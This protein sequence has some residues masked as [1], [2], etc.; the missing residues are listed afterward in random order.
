MAPRARWCTRASAANGASMASAA[1]ADLP[2]AA[3]RA[4]AVSARRGRG[5]VEHKTHP[6]GRLEGRRL[7]RV[8]ID[9]SPQTPRVYVDDVRIR[10]VRVVPYMLK[11]LSAADD[12]SRVPR[13]ID[14]QREL[15]GGELDRPLA[16][17]S[18]A[19]RGVHREIADRERFRHG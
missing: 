18:D 17:S 6:P 5:C 13:E 10:V 2:A 3:R 14:E 16:P 19:T 12:T 9:L 4:L 1:L 11:Q 15:L 7:T 8:V